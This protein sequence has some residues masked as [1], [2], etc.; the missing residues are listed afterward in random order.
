MKQDLLPP[1]PLPVDRSKKY[2]R[3]RRKGALVSFFIS[4]SFSPNYIR[5]ILY[6]YISLNLHELTYRKYQG[7]F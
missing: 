6:V 7:I 5:M 1:Y 4:S 3:G 2:P